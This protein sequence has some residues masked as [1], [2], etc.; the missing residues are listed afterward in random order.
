MAKFTKVPTCLIYCLD[1]NCLQIITLLLNRWYYWESKDKLIDNKFFAITNEDLRQ[2]THLSNRTIIE[3]ISTLYNN[4]IIEVK[5]EGQQGK[6]VPN[7]YAINWNTIEELNK[8]ELSDL[9][10]KQIKKIARVMSCS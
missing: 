10:N 7:Y 6:R 1:R 8:L 5:S 3:V 2:I 4:N 9:K